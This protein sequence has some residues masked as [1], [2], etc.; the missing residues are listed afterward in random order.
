[1]A[2][3]GFRGKFVLTSRAYDQVQN[4]VNKAI[5]AFE[6]GVGRA[7]QRNGGATTAFFNAL[8]TNGTGFGPYAPSTLL[9]KVDSIMQRAEARL[10]FGRGR[11]G[12]TGGV[13]LSF[14]TASTSANPASVAL[15]NFSVAEQL[16]QAIL[17]AQGAANPVQVALAGMET[18][19]ANT[20]NVVGNAPAVNVVPGVLPQYITAFG[21]SGARLFGLKNT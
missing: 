3:L 19:R 6:Q 17:N 21:P 7:F 10:P 15:G 2:T 4:T 8:G 20:L 9:G 11:A 12:S 1:M 14:S 13:G 16:D 5:L 18:V